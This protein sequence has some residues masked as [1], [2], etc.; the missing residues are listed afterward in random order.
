MEISHQQVKK[1]IVAFYSGRKGHKLDKLHYQKYCE[2]VV[3]N[4]V[5]VEA[6]I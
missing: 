1:S 4:V 6:T 2:K 5:C 3:K